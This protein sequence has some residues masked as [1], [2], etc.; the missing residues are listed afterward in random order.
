MN[1][2]TQRIQKYKVIKSNTKQANT[3]GQQ[4]NDR[5]VME[6]GLAPG[7][8]NTKGK[9]FHTLH[10]FSNTEKR[11]SQNKNVLFTKTYEI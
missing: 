3:I 4:T 6:T 2:D 7:N 11:L 9:I 10:F 8:H 5:T 1:N